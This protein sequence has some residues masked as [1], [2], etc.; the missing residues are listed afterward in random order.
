MSN[1]SLESKFTPSDV[2]DMTK[3]REWAVNLG[4]MDWDSTS[5]VFTKRT[6]IEF[7][8]YTG[9]TVDTNFQNI[10]KLPK[11]ATFGKISAANTAATTEAGLSTTEAETDDFKPTRRVRAAPGGA[12]S[13]IFLHL[14][15]GSP[16]DEA[17]SKVQHHPEPAP[18]DGPQHEGLYGFNSDAKPSRRVRSNPGGHSSIGSFFDAPDDQ[19]KAIPS[20]RVRQNPGGQ[21]SIGSLW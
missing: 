13:D 9:T 5:I 10:Q 17:P 3:E 18:T 2:V 1:I 7:L 19:E 14:D 16:I 4:I 6:L 21:D 8:K 11:Y 20:R 12:S 15:D